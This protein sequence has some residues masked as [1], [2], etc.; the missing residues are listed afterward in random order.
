[1]LRITIL[2]EASKTR[3]VLEGKLV[4]A[5]V[6]EF[7]R[8]WKTTERVQERRPV[9]DLGSVTQIDFYGKALLTEM[10]LQGIEL[11]ASGVMTRAII[12]GIQKAGR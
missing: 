1:M 6:G 12:E 3:F 2:E 8:C 7:R 4:G 11:L 9:V 10:H 5:W